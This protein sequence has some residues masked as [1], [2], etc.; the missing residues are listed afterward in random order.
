M[1][2]YPLPPPPPYYPDGGRAAAAAAASQQPPPFPEH[3]RDPPLTFEELPP[4]ILLNIVH[5]TFPQSPDVNEGRLERQRKTLYWLSTSLRL[6]N[7]A[8]YVACMHVL[9]ST[10]LPAYNS[11]IRPPCTSDPFPLGALQ[12][13]TTVLDLFIALKVREDVWADDTEL[14]L[15]REESFKDLFDMMQPRARLE[16]LVRQYGVKAGVVALP[17]RAGA[18]AAA[19]A[20]APIPFAA[21]SISFSPRNVGLLL[22]SGGRKRTIVEVPR[23]KGEKL[24]LSAKKIVEQL[25]LWLESE[26]VR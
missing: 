25:A 13:E 17:G 10:Y 20:I 26:S 7:R 19:A 21:L 12:R 18:A 6:V 3:R 22:Y 24:E 15:E 5:F 4:S 1:L 9:R 16:D 14:H 8:L 11:L 23:V 2:Q